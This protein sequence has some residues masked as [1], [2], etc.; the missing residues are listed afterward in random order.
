MA[1]RV[2][3]TETAAT[4]LDQVAEFIARDSPRY[5]ATIVREARDAARSLSEMAERGRMVPE[6]ERTD[7]RELVV[8]GYRLIYR[9]TTETVTVLGFIH[10]ARDLGG[11]WRRE[12]RSD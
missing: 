4:D 2:E 12:E 1:R 11:L 10:G 6:F 7:L 9:L 8:R 3:W 5:A